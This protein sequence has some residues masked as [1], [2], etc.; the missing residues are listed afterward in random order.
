MLNFNETCMEAMGKNR[1]VLTA[2]SS[3]QCSADCWYAVIYRKTVVFSQK[4]LKI[5]V[6]WL[7]S[8]ALFLCYSFVN[9]A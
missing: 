9:L 1:I 7:N 8:K 2:F 6:K 3:Q 4:D 5:A